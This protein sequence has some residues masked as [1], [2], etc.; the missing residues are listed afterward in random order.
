MRG[1]VLSNSVCFKH[2]NTAFNV[3]AF[4]MQGERDKAL[5]END[6]LKKAIKLF[7]SRCEGPQRDECYNCPLQNLNGEGKQLTP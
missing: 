5:A 7:C 3:C 6:R 2:R 4:C 1:V